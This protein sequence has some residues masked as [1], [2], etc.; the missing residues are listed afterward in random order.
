MNDQYDPNF[1]KWVVTAGDQHYGPFDTEA[2]ADKWVT[3]T[4]ST[5]CTVNPLFP[6]IVS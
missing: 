1:V 5:G 4:H 3:G 2:D 6:G